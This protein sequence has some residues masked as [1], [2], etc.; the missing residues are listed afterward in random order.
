MNTQV[1]GLSLIELV[2]VLAI[3]SLLVGASLVGFN[4]S[5]T[6]QMLSLAAS[7]VAA[8]LRATQQRA[9]LERWEYTAAFSVGSNQY[10][11]AR[12][13]GGWAHRVQLPRGV[14]VVETT[15]RGNKVTFSTF[16]NP[17]HPGVIRVRNRAGERSVHVDAMGRIT[18]TP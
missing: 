16:G 3:V 18:T 6:P 17:D 5:R 14:I 10:G 11:L 4:I 8:D 9:R 2:V 12:A 15:W 1:R 7:Q 13:G